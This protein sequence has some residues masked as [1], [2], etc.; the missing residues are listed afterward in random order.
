MLINK[1]DLLPYVDFDMER[2]IDYAKRVNPDIHIISL[3]S[4]KGENFSV[5]TDWLSD[6]MTA[7]FNRE[8]TIAG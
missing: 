3:S 6:R 5:W 8:Q 4:T 2:C 7:L 1:T